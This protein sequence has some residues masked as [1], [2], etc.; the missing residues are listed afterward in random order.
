MD[1]L[2]RLN[3]LYIYILYFS[4]NIQVG[5]G[6]ADHAFWG[7]HEEMTMARPAFAVSTSNPGSDVAG[8]TAAALAAGSIAFAS[9]GVY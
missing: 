9:K 8:E 7:R 6:D 2:E 1:V 4:S 3:G 5:D